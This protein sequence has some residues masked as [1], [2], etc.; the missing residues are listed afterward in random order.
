MGSI[1]TA[2]SSFM[3][4]MRK[5]SDEADRGVPKGRRGVQAQLSSRGADSLRRSNGVG[6][7][8]EFSVGAASATFDAGEV[9]VI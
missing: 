3:V 4:R 8:V 5:H 6:Q 9:R 7:H 2:S 1:P